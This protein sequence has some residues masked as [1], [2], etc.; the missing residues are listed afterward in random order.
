MI[1]GKDIRKSV[2]GTPEYMPPEV[3]D[4]MGHDLSVDVW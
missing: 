3:V 1:D 2:C 4:K